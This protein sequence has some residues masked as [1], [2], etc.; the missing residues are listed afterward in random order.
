M[1]MFITFEGGEGSGKTTVINRLMSEL[2]GLGYPVVKTREP[3]GSKIAEEIRRI[4]L[5]VDNVAMDFRTEALLYA[6]SR[7]QHLTEVILPN[8]KAGKVVLCDRFIDSSLAYQGHARNLGIKAVYDLNMYA[9]EGLLPDLTFFI[10]IDPAI[11]LQRIATAHRDVDRLDLE[12]G[13]F[14]K[15]VRE[16]YQK[17]AK[18]FPN[19]IVTID[20]NREVEAIV[21][22]IFGIIQKRL[23]AQ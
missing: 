17:V 19:R 3:G 18:M 2:S 13:D 14:H 8:L 21:A 1:S 22:E 10:D 7:R 9:T 23:N 20:G 5:N 16:G 6:A 4:I 11:G 12:K 15:L